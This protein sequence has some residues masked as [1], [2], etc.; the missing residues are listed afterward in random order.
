MASRYPDDNWETECDKSTDS[1]SSDASDI[2]SIGGKYICI[3]ESFFILAC[4][5]KTCSCPLVQ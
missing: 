5:Q 2:D 1:E 3:L 4:G